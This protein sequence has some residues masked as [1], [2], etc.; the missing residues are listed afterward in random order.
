MTKDQVSL[1]P[2]ATSAWRELSRA[3]A[4][5][6]SRPA[7]TRILALWLVTIAVA[8]VFQSQNAAFLSQG[9]LI[10]LL[11]ATSTLA[12]VALGVTLVV[13]AGELDLS[14]GSTYALAP[15]AVAVCWMIWGLPLYVALPLGLVVVA[16]AGAVNG[17]LT[18]YVRI[19]SFVVTLGTFTLL[20]GISL[21]IGKG[22]YFTPAAAVPAV[23]P[24]EFAVFAQLGGSA[25]G[26]IPIQI[27]WLGVISAIVFVVLHLSLFGFRLRAIGG[28]EVAGRLSRLPVARYRIV[29][30]VLSAVLAGWA[31]I[32]D[33]S[34]LQATQPGI[35]GSGLTFPVFAAVI[36]GGASL[37]GG[38]GTVAG[39]LSGALLLQTLANGLSLIGAGS[40]VQ[41]V[42]TG[43]ITIIAV[44]VDRWS[45]IS[46]GIRGALQRRRR[47]AELLRQDDPK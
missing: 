32:I 41:Q 17:I 20:A 14:V 30:F 36:I 46:A 9:N 34:F 12:T 7:V 10:D 5:I 47:E 39:T 19:P 16:A 18:V 22:Q 25:P 44:A 8:L 42:S 37:R 13:V 24:E 27:L 21:L 35:S 33:F 45:D 38:V 11:R 15:T 26:G 43:L 31:G 1:P 3:A 2:P 6:S 23:P 28:N 29:V 4:T 40:G